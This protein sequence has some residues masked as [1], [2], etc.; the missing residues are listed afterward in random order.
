MINTT[1]NDQPATVYIT[2]DCVYAI[3]DNDPDSDIFFHVEIDDPSL[4][5]RDELENEFDLET[6][7]FIFREFGI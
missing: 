2:D 3:Y 7:E 4:D 5:L 6:V 1:C